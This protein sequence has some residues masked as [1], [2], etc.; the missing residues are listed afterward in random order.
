MK[1]GDEERPIV[2]AHRGSSGTAPE[3][4]L[5]AFHAAAKAGVDMVEMDVRMTKDFELVIL[6]DQ[7]VNRTSNGSGAVWDLTLKQIQSL[8][9]GSWFARRFRGERIPSLRQVVESLP[10]TLTLNLEVKTDGDAR[11]GVALGESYL[12]LLEELRLRHRAIISSFDHTFLKRLH[13]LDP[14]LQIG[15]LVPPVRGL[16]RKPS[17]I[18]RAVGANVYICSRRQ[19][20]K[21]IVDDAHSHGLMVA[22]YTVNSRAHAEQALRFGVDAIITDLPA[23]MMRVLGHA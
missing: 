11:R 1:N 17:T 18:A 21:S 12:L 15:V 6:H 22:T 2:V 9:A 4:T 16:M 3:N 20:R 7:T 8:D 23:T 10:P 14:S 19:L 13:L 5:A